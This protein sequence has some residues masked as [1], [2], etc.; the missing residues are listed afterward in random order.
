[1]ATCQLSTKETCSLKFHELR[2][3]HS[4]EVGMED[5]VP[6]PAA[7]LGLEKTPSRQLD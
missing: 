6:L 1:M 4:R 7:R 3:E 2:Q 5:D